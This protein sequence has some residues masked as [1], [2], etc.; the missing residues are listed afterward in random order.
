[1]DSRRGVSGPRARSFC[2]VLATCIQLLLL[3]ELSQGRKLQQSSRQRRLQPYTDSTNTARH[4]PAVK[5][6]QVSDGSWV[7]CVPIE[8]QIAAHHPAL[9]EHIIRMSPSSYLNLQQNHVKPRSSGL[10]P[11]SFAREHGGCPEGCIPVQRRDPKQPLLRKYQTPTLSGQGTPHE[12]AVVGMPSSKGAYQGSGAVLSVNAPVIGDPASEFSLSQL[13]VV[14]GQYDNNSLNTAE[15][16]WQVYPS[17]HPS[18]NPLAPHL[19]VY[20][21]ADAYKSTGC[22]NLGCAGFVQTNNNWVLGGTLS[23][24][25][26]L[27]AHANNEDEISLVVLYDSTIPGWWLSISDTT[28]GYWPSSLYT[29]LQASADLLQWGGEIFPSATTVGHTTTAMGSGAFPIEGYPVT[30]YQRNV[31]YANS[32]NTFFDATLEIQGVTNANCYNSSIEQGDFGSSW[33]SYF[34]FGGPGGGNA[35]CVKQN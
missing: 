29:T 30:A 16:G 11:Q 2:W 18:D 12:Y 1:M 20:W 13:W 5:S 22:Y 31:T 3:V 27:D 19:F 6:F 28:I 24:Y 23:P 32:P 35:A 7:D 15:V 14:A 33:G 34:F 10:H 17:Q 8:Q 21:T 4:G 25:T 9:K 26:T